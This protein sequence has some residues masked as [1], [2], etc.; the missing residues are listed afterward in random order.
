[1]TPRLK[2]AEGYL[3]QLI[4]AKSRVL[5]ALSAESTGDSPRNYQRK[6]GGEVMPKAQWESSMRR[7]IWVN[8]TRAARQFNGCYNT[9]MI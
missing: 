1:L 7:E 5:L 8:R 3:N 9:S 4:S 2:W 6:S